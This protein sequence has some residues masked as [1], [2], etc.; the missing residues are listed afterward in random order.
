MTLSKKHLKGVEAHG[1]IIYFK[2]IKNQSEQKTQQSFC[3]A[4]YPLLN[5]VYRCSKYFKHKQGK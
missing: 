1:K 4:N 5:G 3:R 2:I